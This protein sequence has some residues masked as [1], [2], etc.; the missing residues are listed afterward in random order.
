LGRAVLQV[1]HHRFADIHRQ[2]QPL[3]VIPLAPNDHLTVSPINV[4]QAQ[5]GDL[6][7][8]QTQA[9]QH[10]HDGVITTPER[11]KSRRVV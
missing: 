8:S 5:R 6:P 9:N 11:V 3:G 2:R 7:R 4:I 10:H 1:G